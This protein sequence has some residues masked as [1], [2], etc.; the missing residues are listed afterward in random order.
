MTRDVS[1][2]LREAWDRR[3]AWGPA[4]VRRAL[5]AVTAVREEGARP[6]WDEDAGEGWARVLDDAGVVALVSARLPLVIVRSPLVTADV[7]GHPEPEVVQVE[8]T[9]TSLLRADPEALSM[10]FPEMEHVLGDNQTDFPPEGFTAD[11]LWFLTV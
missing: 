8:A 10:A 3:A 1:S 5:E 9:D 11:E 2:T 4:E 7:F 6:D